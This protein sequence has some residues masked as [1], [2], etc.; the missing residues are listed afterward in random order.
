MP[1]RSLRCF[2]FL[3]L[4][5]AAVAGLRAEE[6]KKPETLVTVSVG[7]VVRATLHA[8][9]TGYGSV[10]TSPTGGARLAAS[11][12]GLVVAVP[13]V[14]GARLEPNAVVVQLDARAAD[15]AVR[16]ART[17]VGNAE[18]ARDRQNELLGAD[19]TSQRAVQEAADRLAAAYAE[20]AAALLQQSQL[21]IRAPLAGTLA[22]I[23]VRPGEW[24]E[25]GKEVGE[26]VDLDRLTVAV[27]LPAHDA[28]A[29]QVGQAASLFARL[30]ADEKPVAEGTVQFVAP[31]VNPATNTVLVRVA[32]PKAS[33]VR[34]GKFT[35]VRI[36][37]ETRADKLAVPA[38]SVVTD[39]EGHYTVSVV[40][41]DVAKQVPVQVGLTEG[42]L[43]EVAGEKIVEG[44]AVVTV[45]AYGLPKETKIRVAAPAAK[46]AGK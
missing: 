20:L 7:K 11:A 37:T 42:D 32:L 13:G 45:G 19:G 15:A 43:V 2:G 14:E 16:R 35:A 27:Q 33:G 36:A 46:E 3:L 5:L 25:A 6:E 26:V 39:S 8:F 18:K 22:R 17:A 21:A 9:V 23:T 10:E 12:A 41:K 30:A 44:A 1:P 40:E 29:V 24:L 31:T 28:V 4:A 34:P 38:E